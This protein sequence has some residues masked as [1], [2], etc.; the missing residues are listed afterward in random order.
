MEWKSLVEKSSGYSVK[1][2]R[3]DN[4][5]EYTSTEFDRYLKKEGIEHQYTIPK[6]PE[7]N[8]V[9][10]RLNRTLV[11]SIRSMIADSKLPHR[12]WAE[13][14]ST[15]AYLINRSPTRALDN[16]TPFEAWYGKK[17]NVDHLRVFVCSAYT[18]V[19]KD[20]RKKLDPKAKKCIFLGYGTARKGYRFYDNKTSKIVY[21]RDIVFNESS[22]GCESEEEKELIQVESFTEEVPEPEAPEVEEPVSADDNHSEAL[23]TQENLKWKM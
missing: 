7:Q 23:I 22:R 3:T 14:L 13:A 10:E 18:H 19:P 12:F 8:G 5:G 15:A 1:K 9:S 2:L 4:G 16:M 6:T 17:P 11:E 21:S 20:E